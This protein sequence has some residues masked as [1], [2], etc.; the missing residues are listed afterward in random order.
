MHIIFSI[1][2]KSLLNRHNVLFELKAANAVALVFPETISTNAGVE[3]A[4]F[5]I[6][7]C[8]NWRNQIKS[9]IVQFALHFYLLI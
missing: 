6:F 3:G 1:E 2:H 9:K 7:H 4:N 8:S 5:C